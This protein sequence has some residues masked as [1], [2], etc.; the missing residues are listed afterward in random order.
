MVGERDLRCEVVFLEREVRRG[1]SECVD[2][3][4]RR[5]AL[6][7]RDVDLDHEA[8]AGSQVRS[9]VLKAVNLFVLRGQVRDR[10]A[11]EIGELERSFHPGGREVADRHGDGVR[12]R[13]CAHLRDHR[14]RQLDAMNANAPPAER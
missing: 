10:V 1:H 9:D 7:L 4:S 13:L 12:A 3:F 5:K 8:A 2:G 11:H 14:R 6:K